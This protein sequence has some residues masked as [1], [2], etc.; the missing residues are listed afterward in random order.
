[1]VITAESCGEMTNTKTFITPQ[2]RKSEPISVPGQSYIME[3]D[4]GFQTT[5]NAEI[6]CQGQDIL[7]DGSIMSGIV[8]HVEYKITIETENRNRDHC[9][10]LS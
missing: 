9:L 3:F 6:R 10:K 2:T 5:P 7:I 4:S 8:S 1:M